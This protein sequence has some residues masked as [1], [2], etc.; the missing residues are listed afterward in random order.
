MKKKGKLGPYAHSRLV[1]LTFPLGIAYSTGDNTA[2]D[3]SSQCQPCLLALPRLSQVD[4]GRPNHKYCHNSDKLPSNSLHSHRCIYSLLPK[5][6][7]LVDLVDG[8]I[9]FKNIFKDEAG[10]LHKVVPFYAFKNTPT[11]ELVLLPV[12]LRC[13]LKEGGSLLFICSTAMQLASTRPV[14]T[15]NAV[16][17]EGD[18]KRQH[19]PKNY[20][21]PA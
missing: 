18:G 5:Y 2:C 12:S 4:Q 20:F 15:R 17:A 11:K 7:T 10:Y 19:K 16:R 3:L 21:V 8:G 9:F 13:C 6:F 14:A 1:Q